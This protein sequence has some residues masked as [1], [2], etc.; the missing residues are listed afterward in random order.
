MWLWPLPRLKGDTRC[1]SAGPV[2]GC[3][4]LE[5]YG[6]LVF[7]GLLSSK[8]KLIT[9]LDGRAMDGSIRGSIR[10]LCRTLQTLQGM[11]IP[12]LRKYKYLP[13][14]GKKKTYFRLQN[15]AQ[16]TLIRGENSYQEQLWMQEPHGKPA[17]F[18]KHPWKTWRASSS[19]CLRMEDF[20]VRSQTC[21]TPLLSNIGRK[22]RTEASK[23]ED[24]GKQTKR[25]EEERRK[26]GKKQ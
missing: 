22:E 26:E 5:N 24:E 17:A 1:C 14:L 18:Q 16:G 8:P 10:Y 2:Q 15:Q 9:Q 25:K 7:V 21:S 13:I 23:Q 20:P 12:V 4:L 19:I 3:D 11:R 6:N